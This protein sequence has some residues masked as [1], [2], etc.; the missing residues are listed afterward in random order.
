[1][2]GCFS[3]I[4]RSGG[5]QVVSL[6]P[7]CLQRGPGIVLHE[8][9]HVLGFWHEHSRAD[10]DRYIRVNWNEILPDTEN[11]PDAAALGPGASVPPTVTRN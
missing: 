6:G 7:S 4:G 2:S 9:M 8:L 5:M 1:M 10:R 3:S 11:N